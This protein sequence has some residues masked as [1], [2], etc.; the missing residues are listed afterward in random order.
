[1]VY[2]MQPLI[3]CLITR[4]LQNLYLLDFLAPHNMVQL[5][6]VDA[7]QKVRAVLVPRKMYSQVSL[8]IKCRGVF[9]SP[10]TYYVQYGWLNS[11]ELGWRLVCCLN[12]WTGLPLSSSLK[13]YLHIWSATGM[14]HVDSNLVALT[15]IVYWVLSCSSPIKDN[16]T[17]PPTEENVVPHE[18]ISRVNPN[19][20]KQGGIPEK[21]YPGIAN[22]K[23][24]L[25]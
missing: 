16:S 22:T 18:R 25:S 5:P 14:T 12:L 8:S 13:R 17:K 15:G 19:G 7:G 3:I 23:G 20:E 24:N 2:P 9:L 10:S 6:V 11:E 21:E 4:Y 1:M